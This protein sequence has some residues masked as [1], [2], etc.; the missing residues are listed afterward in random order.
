M[1]K[2]SRRLHADPWRHHEFCPRD[3]GTAVANEILARVGFGG[4]SEIN[5]NSVPLFTA[6]IVESAKMPGNRHFLSIKSPPRDSLSDGTKAK[7]ARWLFS[8]K[9]QTISKIHINP[10]GMIDQ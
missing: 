4:E 6:P 3:V 5:K 9:D 8:L 2:Y 10:F 1:T 7:Q